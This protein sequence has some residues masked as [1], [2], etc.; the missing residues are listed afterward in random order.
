MELFNENYIDIVE[1]SSGKKHLSRGIS[2][3]ASQDEM[4]VKG[5]IPVYSN[6]PSILEIN[7]LFVP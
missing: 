2:S 7:D 1:K 5:I 6:N 4:T 3:D